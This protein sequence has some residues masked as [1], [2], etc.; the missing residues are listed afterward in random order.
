MC[1]RDRCWRR[2]DPDP[3]LADDRGYDWTQ[4]L[5]W[6]EARG[7]YTAYL[8][9]WQRVSG[10]EVINLKLTPPRKRIRHVRVTTSTDFITWTTPKLIDLDVPLSY[11][12]QF[13]TSAIQPHPPRRTSSSALPSGTC[14]GDRPTSNNRK[15]GFLTPHLS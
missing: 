14:R 3:L 7:R 12:E 6:D 9:G 4:T 10:G 1:I 13:Y 2:I 5:L 11:E 15:P 8:R